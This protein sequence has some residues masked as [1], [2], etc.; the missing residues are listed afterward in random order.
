MPPEDWFEFVKDYGERRARGTRDFYTDERMRNG[1]THPGTAKPDE[2]TAMLGMLIDRAGG[3]VTFTDEELARFDQRG[4]KI[5][6]DPLARTV[7]VRRKPDIIQGEIVP[8]EPETAPPGASFFMPTPEDVE[9]YG[10]GV[11]DDAL[12]RSERLMTLRGWNVR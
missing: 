2:G 7:T 9:T 1:H 11:M 3:S 10:R 5:D 6:R 4:F 12:A 8:D